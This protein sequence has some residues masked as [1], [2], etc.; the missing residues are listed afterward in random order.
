M[1][2]MKI[3]DARKTNLFF[4]ND[5]TTSF[6]KLWG[7]QEI[8]HFLNIHGGNREKNGTIAF[9]AVKSNCIE[10]FNGKMQ[11]L[12]CVSMTAFDAKGFP[13][14]SRLFDPMRGIRLKLKIAG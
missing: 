10:L 1:E 2:T 6:R 5:Q 13:N 3:K 8:Q 11:H 14:Q 7:I 12:A 9:Y 4:M